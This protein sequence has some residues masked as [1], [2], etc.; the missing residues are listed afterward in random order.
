MTDFERL[1][2]LSS[3]INIL[4]VEDNEIARNKTKKVLSRVFNNIDVAI[5]GKEGLELFLKQKYDLVISDIIMNVM[6]GLEMVQAIKSINNDQNVIFLSSYTEQKFLSRAI[7]LGVDGFV[8]KPIDTEIFY[9]AILKSVKQIILKR[10]NFDYKLNLEKQVQERTTDLAIKNYE[11][12]EMVKEVKKVNQL[13][14]EMKVA[15]KVQ[16]SLL[17][18]KIP[19]SKKMKTATYFESAEYVGGDYYDLFYSS[20]DEIN[21][22]IADVSGHGIGP[23]IT[24][25]TFRGVCRSILTLDMKFEEQVFRINNIMSEDSKHNDFF[26]TAFFIK[27][28]EKENRFEYISA[29]HNDMIYYNNNKNIFETLKST[30][31]PLAIFK[32]TKYELI[33]KSLNKNDFLVLY[34]DGL[35]EASNK[36][37]EMLGLTNLINIVKESKSLDVEEIL[38]NIQSMLNDFIEQED[39]KDDTTILI[40][41]FI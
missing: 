11:L 26:I 35:I 30:A 39:K 41:K 21:I 1:K 37:K 17:P 27:Y 18:K 40:T 25:S 7:E 9:S 34:T 29:G 23:A 8:F 38:V 13:K 10:E 20:E 5:H 24:M 19:Q 12:Q 15:Q 2:Q 16:E 4:Y 28:Y 33:N 31:I 36:N 3:N 22:I 6:D 32:D 14:E